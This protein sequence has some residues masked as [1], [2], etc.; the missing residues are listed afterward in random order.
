MVMRS[1]RIEIFHLVLFERGALNGVSR[2]K[3]MLERRSGAQAAQFGLD[4]GPQVS[5]RV[6]TEFNYAAGLALEHNN[7]ASSDLGC[8]NCHYLLILSSLN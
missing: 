5:R 6:V 7:H 8:W 4:H 3:A 2:T 1:I